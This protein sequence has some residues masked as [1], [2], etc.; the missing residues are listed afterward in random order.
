[1]R[2]YRR[3]LDGTIDVGKVLGDSFAWLFYQKERKLLKEHQKH[4]RIMRSAVGTG[5]LGEITFIKRLPKVNH[6]FVIYHGTT[7]FLRLGDI[8]MIDTKTLKVAAIGELKS[9]KL[10]DTEINIT[11]KLV[12]PK[13]MSDLVPPGPKYYGERPTLRKLEPAQIERLNRQITA[14]ENSFKPIETNTIGTGPELRVDWNI[15]KLGALYRSSN[16]RKFTYVKADR[17]L[18]L[19]GLKL[20]RSTLWTTLASAGKSNLTKKMVGLEKG[21]LV[22]W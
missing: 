5:G 16:A 12:G 3:I 18:L 22:T 4:Q 7:T 13:L 19:A 10:G 14:I 6:Y 11:V 15:A 9:H 2:D 17:G 20:P 8:S 1:M 21:A